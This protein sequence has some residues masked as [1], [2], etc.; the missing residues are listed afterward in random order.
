MC[1]LVNFLQQKKKE[2]KL[3]VLLTT[4]RADSAYVLNNNTFCKDVQ[5]VLQRCLGRKFFNITFKCIYLMYESFLECLLHIILYTLA[6][7]VGLMDTKLPHFTFCT[8]EYLPCNIL[9][10]R[11]KLKKIIDL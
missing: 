1:E 8:I 9:Y 5:Y 11:I 7:N 2:K 3:Y 10:T 6:M 4:M